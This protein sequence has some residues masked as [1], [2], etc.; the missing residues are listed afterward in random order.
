MVGRSV[1]LCKGVKD[2]IGVYRL[3]VIE[4]VVFNGFYVDVVS[5]QCVKMCSF[6]VVMYY[7]H[8]LIHGA[9]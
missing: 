1:V 3:W 2:G 9:E 4:V 7:L 6:F 5:L 8:G